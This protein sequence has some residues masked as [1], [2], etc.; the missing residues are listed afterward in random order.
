[1]A[2]LEAVAILALVGRA[3]DQILCSVAI[4]VVV[5]EEPF[6]GFPAEVEH[7]SGALFLVLAIELPIVNPC[8][9]LFNGEVCEGDGFE[10]LAFWVVVG[11]Y[12]GK[13]G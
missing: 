9:L 4:F 6:I 3:V 1:L 2:L 7:D 10:I 12:P 8:L 5:V 11:G 13:L